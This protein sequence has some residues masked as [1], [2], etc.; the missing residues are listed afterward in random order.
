M[1]IILYF[2]QVIS[3][4]IRMKT[5]IIHI[6]TLARHL[7]SPHISGMACNMGFNKFFFC[8]ICLFYCWLLMSYYTPFY[9]ILYRNSNNNMLLTD[10]SK[11]IKFK[12]I[13]LYY[14]I[15]EMFFNFHIAFFHPVTEQYFSFN[16]A[17]N[18][19]LL[20]PDILKMIV[21]F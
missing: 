21:K 2:C 9:V 3:N 11:H 16:T 20:I 18:Y 17:F 13:R 4:E 1:F 19:F 8:L 10:I 6:C 14:L 5:L 7:S 12:P 15:S